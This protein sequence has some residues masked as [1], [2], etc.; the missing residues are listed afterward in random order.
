MLNFTN[1]FARGLAGTLRLINGKNLSYKGPWVQVVNNNT[2]IDEFYLG[3]FMAADYTF[4]VDYSTLRKEMIKCFVVAG[5]S[6]A[7]ITVYGRTNLDEN[8]VNITAA[9]NDSRVTIYASPVV[10]ADGSTTFTGAKIIFS[11]VYY[12]TINEL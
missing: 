4:V 1:Y 10:A 11:A 7:E 2:E 5:P 3:E 8:L 6:K 12:E 9:V